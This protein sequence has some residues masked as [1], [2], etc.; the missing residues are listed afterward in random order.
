VELQGLLRQL[1]S[2]L[3][4]SVVR[5]AVVALALF[6]MA[7]YALAAP[8][9]AEANPYTLSCSKTSNAT[10]TT[11]ATSATDTTFTMAVG[12]Q[13]IKGSAFKCAGVATIPQG[14]TSIE[15]GAFLPWT[16][17]NTPMENPY[18]TSIVW[19]TSV[20]AINLG[21]INL[22]GLTSFDIPSSV[23]TI[24]SQSFQSLISLTS[25][26]I[27]GP[28]NAADTLVL[29]VYAFNNTVTSLT[30]G[31]GYVNFGANFNAGA[32]FRSVT[33][34]PNVKSIGASAFANANDNRSYASITFPAGV[35]TIGDSAF[36]NNPY[37]KTISFGTVKP[38]ITA[39]AANAFSGSTVIEKIQYCGLIDPAYSNSVV[40][41][42]LAAN[43][44]NVNVYC[45]LSA[46]VPTVSNVNPSTG[47][48]AGGTA[49][50]IQ[51]TNLSGARV[52]LNG[53]SVTVTNNTASSLQFT[54]PA[55]TL[56]SKQVR[57]VTNLGSATTSFTYVS[58]L[59]N[60]ITISTTPQTTNNV[61]G[62]YTPAASAPGGSVVITRDASSLGVCTMGGDGVVQFIGTGS[63][64]IN[65]N[66]AGNASYAAAQSQQTITVSPFVITTKNVVVTAP[67]L[68][69]TPQTTVADNGQYTATVTWSGS[70]SVF[71]ANTVYTATVTVAPLANW[72]LTGVTA[73]FF[74]INGIAPTSQNSVNAG[75]FQYAFAATAKNIITTSNV[76]VAAPVL[77]ATPQTAV[78]DN[79]QFTAT[80]T[81]SGSPSVFAANTI[82]TATV[83][84][85]PKTA[86]TLT[87]VEA[88]FFTINGNAPTSP[89][90]VNA[91]SL[92][93]T[94]PVTAKNIISTRNVVVTAPVLG[95]TPQASV[96]DN[97]QYTATITWSD[98]PTTF[99][100][101]TIYTATVTVV[102]NTNWT[103]TGVAANFFTING[104]APTSP[105][106]ANAGVFQ[107]A[108]PATAKTTI[109]T[110]NVVV[111]A[112]VL[113][114]TP[115]ASV[116][117]NGQYSAT[118]TWSGSPSIFGP[119]TAYTATVT[120]VANTNWTLTGVAANFFTINGN[121][122]TSPNL[123]NAGVFQYAFPATAK[124]TITT[125]NVL[126]TAPVLGAAPQ[127]AV[128][129]NGQYTATV[130]WSSSPSVFAANT[131]YTATVNIS[132]K[133]EYTLTG[134]AANFFTVNGNSATTGNLLNAGIFQYTFPAYWQ[135]S[136]VPNGGT[137]LQSA[138]YF[139]TGGTPSALPSTS[140]FTAPTGKSFGG[141]ATSAT[142]TAPVTAAYQA[143]SPVTYYAIWTQ[144]SHTVIFDRNGADGAETMSNQ[145]RS[146]PA[147]LIANTYSYTD[148]YFLSWNT[149]ADGTGTQY[150]DQAQFQFLSN[151]RLY[152]QWGKVVTYRITGADSG[153]PS[154]SSDNWTSGVISL[155]TQGS[156][157]KAGYSFGG[158]RDGA[159]TYTTTFTPTTVFALDP[160]WL[161][162]TYVISFSKT[163]GATGSVPS[164]QTWTTGNSPLI[165][166]GNSG[167]PA[168]SLTGYTFGGWATVGAPNTPVTTYSTF[169]D[170]VLIPIWNPIA[171]TVAYNLNGGDGST[172][173]QPPLNINQSIS[174]P[175]PT[176]SNFAFLGW[177]LD[178]TSTR[179]SAGFT[180]TIG[181]S[182]PT[183]QS[184]TAQWVAQYT[185]SYAMNGSTTVLSD[186]SNVG[187][188]NAGTAITL[189]ST[190]NLIAGYSFAGWL[191]SNGV[192][193]PAGSSF[194]VIQNSVLSAQ[195][196][197]IPYSVTYSLGVVAGTPPSSTA[198]TINSTFNVAPAPSKPG[199]T[200]LNWN[201]AADGSGN[202]YLGNQSY[203][204]TTVGN[205]LL[206][207]RW[208]QIP[209][210]VTYDLGGGTGT[211][212]STLT[213]RFIGDTFT[214]PSAGS[215]PTW[216]AHTFKNWSDGTN[217]YAPG[218]TYTLGA[219]SVTLT[220]TYQLNGT[221]PITYSFGS[222]PGTGILP[223][224]SAELEGT[225]IQLKSGAGISRSGHAFAGWTDG[226][227]VYQAG[228]SF[229]VPVF[230][231]PVTFSPVWNTGFA[232]T[233][234][235]GTGS[236]AV[237][238][239]TASRYRG[240]TF[241]V[242]V[243]PQTLVKPGFTLI[244]WSD[245]VKTF[246]AGSTYTVG[247][248]AI[249]LTAQ[250][251]QNS[252]FAAQG[253]PMIELSQKTLR[254]GVG[255]PMESFSV[256]SSVISYS[257]PADAFGN[258]T[259][260]MDF[261]V[262][263]LSDSATLA[264][265][266]PTN[267][268]Y[269]LP[270][271]VSWLA[272]DGTVPDAILPL[273]QTITSN[274]IRVGTTAY[275]ITG[276]TYTVLGVATQ[277]G[278]ITISITEDPLIV[279]G[280]P[281][282]V[283][284]ESGNIGENLPEN[285]PAEVVDPGPIVIVKPDPKPKTTIV[286]TPLSTSSSAKI[287][288]LPISP[289][290]T[291]VWVMRRSNTKITLVGLTTRTSLT[292]TLVNSYG[293]VFKFPTVTP[294]GSSV[295]LQAIKLLERGKHTLTIRSGKSTR[296][297]TVSVR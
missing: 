155:P 179:F 32:V 40:D 14:V 196:T 214:L 16:P 174:L 21:L 286:T 225:A 81:W 146:A 257:I 203:S 131:I 98:S 3:R 294:K 5:K 139:Q 230:T 143:E 216:K 4:P 101:N 49:V 181:P 11:Q 85:V 259:E 189:A 182:S 111:T 28:A 166:P 241:T 211:V 219:G 93:Y 114:A 194:T 8:T 90:L 38:G 207:A 254:A 172:P 191:D 124:T 151:T 122:P 89:N 231:N 125:I 144:M 185:V 261:R 242:Q 293:Q 106:L 274:Q 115:Q 145:V 176:R 36:A 44:P 132:P 195:W 141:W 249:S 50:T 229:F 159:T 80:V 108:F 23:K 18:L 96:I 163:G 290:S 104:N 138:Q 271:I 140:S 262:F 264:S 277:D 275:A 35:T 20:T 31:N 175:T 287:F 212:P 88:S 187:L 33:L 154:R 99:A 29:P 62:T 243:A 157:V 217:F 244:G 134:V 24:A 133:S 269:I 103:L 100:T 258:K 10:A 208:S 22:T 158:W 76:V 126:V 63:C 232:V 92:Q 84:I 30:I 245:G 61:G 67:V 113:G 192:L 221:T 235:A 169:S 147:N 149:S 190:P 273:T 289:K 161:A 79:G 120:V 102:A 97:G 150:A 2:H 56:G 109:T 265:I 279:L 218:S 200:F 26:T 291:S 288:T 135:I 60:P 296:V 284:V 237:P 267:Q 193:R 68:G 83:N 54:T 94:F 156:M 64:V 119:N 53:A 292:V 186:P 252:L 297:I 220:A 15:F 171:Y 42:Y 9:P 57:V 199:Y 177:Q 272:A 112:P 253:T 123:A 250:W 34:G 121:A 116:I 183:A 77:G 165:L 66:Q 75:V 213:N 256:G 117:D 234:S 17:Q 72:T 162:N 167:S 37:L 142:S 70:P 283:A 71:A 285:P 86:Y 180:L 223:T 224:Q 118:V 178:G 137:G 55:G 69:A 148:R 12:T 168:L 173:T 45:S 276:T 41:A 91:G 78:A 13:L 128:A 210:T 107:Y 295:S 27:Q 202:S 281:I 43:F 222:N 105:N 198:T 204:V 82:Y 260:N 215:S 170:Q 236:G 206:T 188:F 51:G 59:P 65:F 205:I 266:L 25:A 1:L 233:Y 280:N 6:L 7:A 251:M 47:V 153:L 238:T 164:N 248:S 58:Q 226:S 160:V 184:F 246:K 247:T 255:Y 239:D 130:T 52:Y 136:F 268:T 87:G 152:A 197:P 48:E 39:I 201:T 228:D 46:N 240:D 263:S 74:T 110:R 282:P 127:T 227:N 270:T 209:Y 129:D 73:N 95:A 278:S 19:P